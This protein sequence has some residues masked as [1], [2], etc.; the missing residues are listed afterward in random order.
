LI[1]PTGP[2]RWL[3][4]QSGETADTLASLREAKQKGILTLGIINV[5][6]SAIARETDA[7]V[8][9]HAGPEIGVASTKAFTSQMTALAFLTVFLGR[10]RAMSHTMGER[11]IGEI[12]FL[13]KY[14]SKTLKQEK[15]IKRIAGKHKNAR[16]F[17]FLGRKYN[18]PV[19]LEGALKLKEISYIHAE[20]YA[21]GELKH[22]P[23]AMID[24][25]FP[26]VAIM[27]KDSVYEKM[28]SN[29]EE[30]KARGGPVIAVTTQNN[31]AISSLTKD[32]I[33][34]PKT[35]EMLTP[36]IAAVPLQLFAYYM[37]VSKGYNVDKPRN[38]A[39]SVTVE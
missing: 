9:N 16:D 26:T 17:I 10:Q 11:I 31:R 5:V 6:G 8:Y 14:I 34:I 33:Y 15:E 20:G 30:I 3:S 38:L 29:I 32:V 22:G 23:I 24:K 27:P 1:Y 12:E 19:A 36:I 39:K 2:S 7:G 37:G 21:G 25:S 13:P 4:S 18:Y 28:V 35:L